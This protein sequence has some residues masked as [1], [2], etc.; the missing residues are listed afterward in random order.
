[1]N[2]PVFS[3]IIVT[4]K[5]IDHLLKAIESVLNQTLT[6][7]ECLIF[8]D[9]PE[10]NE[11]IEKLVAGLC[12]DR[13]S[14]IASHSSQGANHWRNAGIEMANG[15]Y[16]AFLDDDDHWFPEKLTEHYHTHRNHDAFVVYS[17]YIKIWPNSGQPHVY[18]E[19]AHLSP[20]IRKDM[21]DGVFSI[22]TTS[23]VSLLNDID[24]QVFDESLLSFQDWDAWFNLTM[25][26][27]DAK[28][29]HIKKPLIYYTHHENNKAT[30]NYERRLNS[31]GQVK[32]KYEMSGIDV[33]GFFFKEMLNLL[34]IK[35][36]RDKTS[37]FLSLTQV[38]ALLVTNPRLFVYPYTYRR[39]GRFLFR[40]EGRL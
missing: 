35:L 27:P 10:D 15:Q 9:F 20:N 14:F 22:S 28:F 8:N 33:S 32:E 13:F 30:K 25:V 5:R 7:Y 34:L 18:K 3:I 1:M 19:N 39:I 16:I 2:E 12:D 26:R 6:H 29:C 23:S 4:F 37:K 40:N 21:A 36:K 11:K 17:D 24:W 31:L 38:L